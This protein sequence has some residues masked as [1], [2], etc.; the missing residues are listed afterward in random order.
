MT[1][2]PHNRKKFESMG[3]DAVRLDLLRGFEGNERIPRG[4]ERQEAF[5]WLVEED[6]KQRRRE[7]RHYWGIVVLTA[8]AAIAACM[9][10]WPIVEGWLS[11][12][13][14]PQSTFTIVD[15]NGRT[16]QVYPDPKGR[17]PLEAILGCPETVRE[18]AH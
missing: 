8:I 18:G 2:N 14:P 6:G 3:I 16:C 15:P 7:T 10:A 12:P 4:S 9:A 13:I 1:I 11:L 5:E 17:K